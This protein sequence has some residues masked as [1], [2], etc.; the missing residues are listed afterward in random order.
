LCKE[1]V[2]LPGQT[3]CHCARYYIAKDWTPKKLEVLVD[4]P[5]HLSLEHLR[6]RGLQPGEQPQPEVRPVLFAAILAGVGCAHM[7][8]AARR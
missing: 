5:D 7:R 3:V 2:P 8:V 6:G 1:D 4:V